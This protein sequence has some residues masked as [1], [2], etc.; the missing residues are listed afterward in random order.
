[1]DKK[2]LSR[3]SVRS[4]GDRGAA[5]RGRIGAM[6]AIM[7]PFSRKS[8]GCALGLAVLLALP[9]VAEPTPKPAGPE[10]VPGNPMAIYQKRYP[11][12]R[13][14]GGIAVPG[15]ARGFE[16]EIYEGVRGK[17]A[18]FS[19]T[20]VPCDPSDASGYIYLPKH[21]L[22][23]MKTPR[24]QRYVLSDWK[25]M[26]F[27]DP[28]AIDKFLAE[29]ELE[30]ARRTS[31]TKNL[32]EL[33]KRW[34]GRVVLKEKRYKQILADG[35]FIIYQALLDDDKVGSLL[36]VPDWNNVMPEEVPASVTLGGVLKR[37][38]YLVEYQRIAL[39]DLYGHIHRAE[40]KAKKKS[41]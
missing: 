5:K 9:A 12:L 18:T 31:P 13:K 23:V 3:V 11:D 7:K 22:I 2:S 30:A 40:R 33:F 17:E 4:P 1:M 25:Q 16:F 19:E 35:K 28:A 41:H 27:T 39:D 26:A 10:P 20:F 14:T 24:Q 8:I 15:A 37:V 38:D 6:N 36:L 32:L 21:S 29:N 34:Y